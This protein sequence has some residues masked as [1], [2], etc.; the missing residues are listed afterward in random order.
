M[1]SSSKAKDLATWSNRDLQDK[2]Q[3]LILKLA[4]FHEK[5]GKEKHLDR[6]K[7][8]NTACAVGLNLIYVNKKP[9][10]P[11]QVLASVSGSIQAQLG[12]IDEAKG[13][14][15]GN[16]EYFKLSNQIHR[17]LG[18]LSEG[19]KACLLKLKDKESRKDSELTEVNAAATHLLSKDDLENKIDLFKTISATAV[20][21]S[22]TYGA[23]FRRL[24]SHE[25]KKTASGAVLLG[26]SFW[27]GLLSVLDH[28]EVTKPADEKLSPFTVQDVAAATAFMVALLILLP[29]FC[30][31][32]AKKPALLKS[33]VIADDRTPL[34]KDDSSS[35][36][37]VVGYGSASG[38]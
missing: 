31:S 22:Q 14:T 12:L 33:V 38:N 15:Q 3:N 29:A 8:I 23:F 11:E 5:F 4:D 35:I 13:G 16:Q 17:A 21:E 28:F 25:T 26:L 24:G 30:M 27:T 20:R 1:F 2:F 7:A 18:K 9:K 19:M 36:N 37:S 34:L 10:D 6:F 32:R